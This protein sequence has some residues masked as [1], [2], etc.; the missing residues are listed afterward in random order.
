MPTNEAYP[1]F[2]PESFA[3]AT[4]DEMTISVE[5]Q[6]S[7]DYVQSYLIIGAGVF[8]ASTALHLK[9]TKPQAR[10]LLIDRL[11]PN[12]AAASSDLSKIIR[13]DYGDIFYMKLALEAQI[14]WQEDP[15]YQPH[16]HQTGMLFAENI[17]RGPTFLRNYASL[18]VSTQAQLMTIDEA[19][20]QFPTLAQG[21]WQGVKMAYY[22]PASGWGDAE[23][24]LKAVVDAAIAEGVEF[25]TGT[26]EK[27]LLR[28][29]RSNLALPNRS[30][31]QCTG[32]RLHGG[33]ELKANH[34]LLSTGASTARLLA[35]S[36]PS[37]PSFYSAGRLVAAAALSCTVRVDPAD[38]HSYR[39]AP[40]FA[41]LMSH[42]SGM[43]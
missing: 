22:N 37:E 18:G 14:A 29:F 25:H 24:A 41:N 12:P 8:G 23:P 32:V 27:L 34:I 36:A 33:L 17:G 35:D 43:Y 11:L 26:V 39:E 40:V 30:A 31:L 16:F 42:T 5:W 20:K 13:A 28:R 21:N 2:T 4:T 19:R 38:W 6:H 9:R 10:V 1:H 7:D 15:L 3:G